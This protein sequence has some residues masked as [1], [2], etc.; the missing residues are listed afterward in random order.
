MEAFWHTLKGLRFN[1]TTTLP[2]MT[3]TQRRPQLRPWMRRAIARRYLLAYALVLPVVIWRLA[4]SIYPFLYTAYLSFFDN[5]PVRRTFDFVGLDNYANAFR[6]INVP[7]AL[8]F[9]L[10]FTVISVS[11]QV[12]LAL[13][14]AEILNRR[15]PLRGIT[16]AINLLPWAMSGIVIATAAQ[17]IF[18][19]NYGLI[20]DILWRINGQRPLWLVHPDTARMAVVLTDVWKNTAFLAVVYLSGLQGISPELHEA[21]K[22]D[23]ANGPRAYWYITLPQLMPLIISTAIFGA[24]YRVL[25]FELVYALTSGGPGTSTMLLGYLAYLQAFRVLNFGYASALSMILFG[26]VLIVGLVGFVF[27]RRAWARL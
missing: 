21:A 9:S 6:D 25:S 17:W 24:I 11:L 26:L 4:T 23:G 1:H 10:F 8:N 18:N 13:G 5:S 19:E 2:N 16:R 22:I 3:L 20:N 7:S 15:F 12:V 14:I 27:L